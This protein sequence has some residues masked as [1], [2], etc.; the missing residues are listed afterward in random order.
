MITKFRY[1]IESSRE[2]M[3]GLAQQSS[4]LS[5][6]A[7]NIGYAGLHLAQQTFSF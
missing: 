2:V 3:Q 1:H 7:S 6:E 4:A 5:E